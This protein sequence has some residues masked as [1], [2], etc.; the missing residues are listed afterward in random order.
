MPPHQERVRIGRP[1]RLLR[2]VEGFQAI[3]NVSD[4]EHYNLK[5]ARFQWIKNH[6]TIL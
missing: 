5:G 2:P 4:I 6:S 1:S 3:Q